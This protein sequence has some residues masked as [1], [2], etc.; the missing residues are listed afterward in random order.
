MLKKA[1]FQISLL[2]GTIIGAGLFALPFVFKTA[3]L[4][5][6][7]FYLAT[8]AFAYVLIHLLYADLVIRTEG[9]HRFVGYAKIYLG[10]AAFL[11]AAL[12]T[13]VQMLVVLAIYV[14]L[15]KSFSGLIIA[16]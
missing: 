8:A 1:I 5:A 2:S 3:G 9:E 14:I 16:F 6:G 15:S 13:I 10:R 12:M 7:F 4:S 11:P